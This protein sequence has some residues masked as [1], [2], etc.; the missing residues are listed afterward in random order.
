MHLQSYL[1]NWIII[2]ICV[3]LSLKRLESKKKLKQ[4]KLREKKQ[5]DFGELRGKDSVSNIAIII[6]RVL[7]EIKHVHH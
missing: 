7:L 4:S 6:V 5:N 3:A 1:S 2:L